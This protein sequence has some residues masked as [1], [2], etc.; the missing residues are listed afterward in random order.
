MGFHVCDLTTTSLFVVDPSINPNPVRMNQFLCVYMWIG[1]ETNDEKKKLNTHYKFSVDSCKCCNCFKVFLKPF[2]KIDF[3][4]TICFDF[5]PSNLIW[6][7]FFSLLLLHSISVCC[8]WRCCIVT[9]VLCVYKVE[10]VNLCE[11]IACNKQFKIFQHQIQM[12]KT[13]H[14][15]V[16]H[17]K[18]VENCGARVVIA[19]VCACVYAD[20]R[21]FFFRWIIS[22]RELYYDIVRSYFIVKT[23]F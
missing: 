7:F 11:F 21:H 8:C 12:E 18:R 20:W 4:L 16:W 6:I 9:V 1:N 3:W 17:K 2:Y 13:V 23:H 14:C 5:F 15:I 19:F 22:Y 10:P